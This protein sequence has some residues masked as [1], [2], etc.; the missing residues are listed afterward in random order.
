MR[1]MRNLIEDPLMAQLIFPDKPT[2]YKRYTME[3]LSNRLESGK[4]G[5]MYNNLRK[6]FNLEIR[7]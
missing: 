2:I 7:Q 1:V 6:E 5:T 3:D 4:H